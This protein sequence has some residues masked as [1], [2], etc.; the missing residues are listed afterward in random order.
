MPKLKVASSHDWLETVMADSDSFL[1]DH[2]SCER[3]ASAMALSLVSH[4]PDRTVLVQEMMVLAREELE[5]FH[6]ML[7]L[8]QAKGLV[9]L[10]DE[11]DLYVQKLQSEIRRGSEYYFLDRL[12]VAGIIETRGCER[13][14]MVADVLEPGPLKAFYQ[15]ITRAESQHGALF[16]RLARRYFDAVQASDR[17]EQL[18]DREA[19]ILKSLPI[20]A[21]VH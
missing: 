14:G 13:F 19:K 10:P 21:V 7:W 5:H 18:L 17:Q 3:K 4:Y 6:Q 8:T 11:K 9:L 12:L 15:E 2:A 1:L 16:Y 20:R